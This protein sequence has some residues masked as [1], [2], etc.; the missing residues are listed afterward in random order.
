MCGYVQA[1]AGITLP[2]PASVGLHER[3]GFSRVATFPGIG[4][5]HQRWHDVGFWQLEL[6][7]RPAVP[8]P[9]RPLSEVVG[10]AAWRAVLDVGAPSSSPTQS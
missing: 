1:I 7:P 4:Y 6:Q 3:L 9:T 2:N 8:V 5:K 10:T